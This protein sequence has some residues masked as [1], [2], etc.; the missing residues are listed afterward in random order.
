MIILLSWNKAWEY[1]LYPQPD[2]RRR[3][4]CEELFQYLRFDTNQLRYEEYSQRSFRDIATFINDSF[5]HKLDLIETNFKDSSSGPRLITEW[6]FFCQSVDQNYTNISTRTQ[7]SVNVIEEITKFRFRRHTIVTNGTS[8]SCQLITNLCHS[9]GIVTCLRQALRQ[10]VKN[11]KT[12]WKLCYKLPN[13]D[14]CESRF[15]TSLEVQ[16]NKLFDHE[17]IELHQYDC[18]FNIFVTQFVGCVNPRSLYGLNGE[19]SNQIEIQQQFS[20][21]EKAG[22]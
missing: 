14:L 16:E 11:L 15:L 8:L 4:Q 21:L 6:K 19:S 2:R 1:I 5:L 12:Q 7:K 10:F 20:E 13:A 18:T 17:G 9:F 22:I 3:S